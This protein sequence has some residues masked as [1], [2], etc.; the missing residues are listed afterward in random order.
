M[1]RLQTQDAALSSTYSWQRWPAS[2]TIDGR[3]ETVCASKWQANAWLSVQ[4]PAGSTVD[5]VAIYNRADNPRYAAWLGEFEIYVSDVV[6]DTS[7]AS[8]VKCAGPVSVPWSEGGVKP[9][10][11]GCPSSPTGTYVT[12]KQVGGAR[13]LTIMEL[14]AFSTGRQRAARSAAFP[15]RNA[16]AGTNAEAPTSTTH[17]V[18]VVAESEYYAEA[19]QAY[20][21]I[22]AAGSDAGHDLDASHDLDAGHGHQH[23]E[24]PAIAVLAAVLAAV[25]G[26]CILL[27]VY[28]LRLRRRIGNAGATTTPAKPAQVV[29]VCGSV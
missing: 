5:Y 24:V 10:L 14:E 26:L 6:G 1:V 2:N 18:P 19:T 7:S 15:S 12:L 8:S 29:E 17:P 16:D 25:V 20:L 4:V 27:L 28:A 23:G 13:Y 9:F 21:G 3:L 11:V 22:T